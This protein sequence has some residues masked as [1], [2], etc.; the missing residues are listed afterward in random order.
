MCPYLRPQLSPL[1]YSLLIALYSFQYLAAFVSL[2]LASNAKPAAESYASGYSYGYNSGALPF[3]ATPAGQFHA[4]DEAGQYNYGYNGPTSSKQETRTADGVVRGTYSYLDANGQLQTVNYISDILGFRTEATNLP[5]HKVEVENSIGYTAANVR[6]IPAQV[7][8]HTAKPVQVQPPTVMAPTVAYSYL[9]YANNFGYYYNPNYYQLTPAS[10]ITSE[11]EKAALAKP[12]AYEGAIQQP[13]PTEKVVPTEYVTQA[14]VQIQPVYHQQIAYQAPVQTVAYQTPVQEV[15]YQ[16]PVQEVQYQAAVQTPVAVAPAVTYNTAPVAPVVQETPVATA[17]VVTYNTAPVAPVAP[18]VQQTPVPV[19][20]SVPVASP[21]QTQYHA[22]DEY[23]QYKFGFADPN[24]ARTEIK[25]ADG[26]VRGHYNYVDDQGNIQTVHYIADKLGFRTVSSNLPVQT[27]DLPV[28]VVDT[29]EVLAA[30]EEHERIFAETKAR[31]EELRNL[32]LLAVEQKVV[33]VDPLPEPVVQA[34]INEA[35]IVVAKASAAVLP[36]AEPELDVR[37]GAVPVVAAE[38]APIVRANPIPVSNVQQHA[39]PVAVPVANKQQY[40]AQDEAGQYHYGYANADSS[41]AEVRTSD[42]VVRGAYN[43][44]D[45]NGESR[46][47]VKIKTHLFIFIHNF[48]SRRIAKCS[49][50]LWCIGI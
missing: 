14:Q 12:V 25:T 39:V 13:I 37:A 35:P 7:A 24:S 1:A 10:P 41:K 6:A 46:H 16:A 42:G 30:R 48:F 8:V 27:Y 26:T 47:F 44:I 19:A 43:Y 15:K 9:P 2:V 18:V 3:Q 50:H 11:V 49:V 4:Q 28:S 29:P 45:A 23:G 31:D 40:H 33:A 32:Q 21:I 36:D 17:P 20:P 34:P 5:E 22:Q 38:S